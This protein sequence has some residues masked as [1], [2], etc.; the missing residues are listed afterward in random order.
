MQYR[1]AFLAV[2]LSLVLV[3]LLN[4]QT[5]Q[6]GNLRGVVTD[7]Q[8]T[9]LPGVT[10]T[11]T[12]SALMGSETAVTNARG[13]YRIPVLPP[14]LD[15][16]VVAELAGFE[17]LRREGIVVR[18]GMTVTINLELREGTLEEEITV[19]APS[20]AIDVVSTKPTPL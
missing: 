7:S 3:C 1:K 10:I 15:Y 17:T 11:V 2:F 19:V 13:A 18:V 4:A 12:G 14:G 6:S 5:R 16:S 8:G 20:P 9:P